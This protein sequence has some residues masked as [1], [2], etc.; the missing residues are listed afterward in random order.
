MEIIQ[1]RKGRGEQGGKWSKERAG[2]A[3]VR[4]KERGEQRELKERK[5]LTTPHPHPPLSFSLLA[6]LYIFP[7][8]LIVRNA[9]LSLLVSVPTLSFSLNLI[10]TPLFHS[11]SPL[12]VPFFVFFSCH[13]SFLRLCCNPLTT[14]RMRNKWTLS[15]ASGGKLLSHA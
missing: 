8:S 7:S 9:D 14:D 5:K 4:E 12:I 13:L 10:I 3:K 6:F 2:W 1:D 11:S 15:K